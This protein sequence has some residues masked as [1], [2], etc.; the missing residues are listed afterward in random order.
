MQEDIFVVPPNF[1]Q[2][3]KI[4]T[5]LGADVAHAPKVMTN[6]VYRFFLYV[7]YILEGAFCSVSAC[8]RT[9]WHKVLR[10]KSANTSGMETTVELV[11][12]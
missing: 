6:V 2:D 8:V 11:E 5:F 1:L 10:S 4:N 7:Y 3:M 12:V 9:T